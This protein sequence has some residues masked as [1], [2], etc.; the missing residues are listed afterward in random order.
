[1][2][3][4]NELITTFQWV[5]KLFMKTAGRLFWVGLGPALLL[6]SAGP[7]MFELVFGQSWALAG[8]Y[9]RSLS[10]MMLLQFVA[11]PL[12]Q[13]LNITERQDL[14]LIWDALRFVIVIGAF[15]TGNYLAWSD[16]VVVFLFSISMA[17]CYI[18]LLLLSIR[19]LDGKESTPA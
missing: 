16:S 2:F 10:L 17:F 5:K 11:A 18:I 13:T 12:S 7:W 14:Q 1:M 3:Y 4:R 19:A 8:S 9:A 6:A 15:G